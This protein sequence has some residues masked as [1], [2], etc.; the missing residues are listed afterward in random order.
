[1][2]RIER[3]MAV[4]GL[5]TMDAYAAFLRGNTQELDLLF[6]EVLIG[7]TSFFRYRDVWQELTDTALPALLGLSGTYDTAG[8]P[9][10]RAVD[11]RR[12]LSAGHGS[13]KR[14]RRCPSMAPTGCRS[15]PPI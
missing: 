6:K 1:M 15:L 8:A 5:D 11:R 13:P 4:H 14:S 2:R 7:V 10:W 9:G 3:R 12:G